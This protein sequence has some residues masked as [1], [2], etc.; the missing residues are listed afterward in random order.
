MLTIFHGIGQEEENQ[1]FRCL[2]PKIKKTGKGERILDSG[3]MSRSLCVQLKG[4]GVEGTLDSDGRFCVIQNL[5]PGSVFGNIYIDPL[6]GI[7][8]TAIASSE[9]ETLFFSYDRILRLCENPCSYHMQFVKNLMEME[10]QRNKLLAVHLSILS[11][12]TI[13]ERLLAYLQ[14]LCEQNGKRKIKIPTTLLQL[15]EYLHVDRSAM[16]REIR[17]LKEEGVIA[18]KGR[19]FELL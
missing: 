3:D 10:A 8:H 4:R 1:L 7:L 5:Q 11:R 2:C 19:E 12:P 14:Y 6:K 13:Q 17:K 9:S 15:A 16:M 18:S